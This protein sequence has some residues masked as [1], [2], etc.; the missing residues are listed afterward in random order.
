MPDSSQ[1]TS[2]PLSILDL[3]PL[4]EGATA[5]DALRD[6]LLLAQAAERLGY[7]RYWVAEHHN[8][9]GVA[10]SATSVLIGYLAAGTS[11]LR[12]GSGGVM[13]PNHSPLV[14]AEQFG[15]L[16]T[17]YPG[18]I[19]LGVGRAPGTDGYASRALRRDPRA[20]DEF[21]QDVQELQILLGP[22]LENQVVIA[23]PG[24]DTN[25]PVYILGSSMFGAQLAALLGL[26]YAFASHFAP[27][28][29]EEAVA[30]YREHF[31]PSAQLQEPYVIAGVNALVADTDERARYLFT[32]SLR[33][34][35]DL[36]KPGGGILKPPVDPD[37]IGEFITPMEQMQANS[38]LRY[39][40]VGAPETVKAAL[41]AFRQTA[42]AD[43]LIVVTNTFDHADRIRSYELLADVMGL[44]GEAVSS[45][46]AAAAAPR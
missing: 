21:P 22:R 24:I 8:M 32:S 3:S 10:S 28:A 16:A 44:A 39:A 14:I 17:L 42:Q 29:L 11:T 38:M 34:F 12:L 27:D 13:L 4:V 15:T 33:R 5:T 1:H 41:T 36:R 40:A 35:A 37:R 2:F 46:A 6:S 45:P 23:N 25:V 43:E 7:T 26:P 30:W 31:E 18:R 19:D 20:G 9:I